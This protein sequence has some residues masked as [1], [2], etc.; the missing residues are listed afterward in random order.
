MSLQSTV[1][2]ILVVDHHCHGVLR[3][4]VNRAEFESMLTEADEPGPLNPTLFDSQIGFAVRRW[5]APVLGLEP[6]AQ[7]DAYLQR[8]T[9]IGHAEVTRRFLREAGTGTYIV[10]TGFVP[11]PILDPTEM[12]ATV[13]GVSLEVVRLE[14]VAEQ[15]IGEGVDASGFA[16]AV[17][18]RLAQRTANAVGVK[19][20][21]AYRAGLE[22]PGEQPTDAEVSAAAGRWLAALDAGAPPRC[23][24]RVL[25]SFLVWAGIELGKP[26]QFHVGLGDSDTDLRDGNPLLLTPL[27][28]ATQ[29]RGVPIMLLHNY[30][31]HRYAGYLAQVF[32]HVFL[33]LG[34]ATHNLGASSGRVIEE[35]LEL[36]PFGKVLFS[37]DA[38]G[39]PELYHLGTLLFRR[40]LAGVLRNGVVDGSWTELDAERT[41]G[42]ILAGNAI[43]AYRL[44]S[45]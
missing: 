27:L 6:H 44:G 41:A 36:A 18:E 15:V 28:R 2:E 20:I 17:R 25:H 5:C 42:M 26:V 29:S 21:A 39:L 24:D 16:A 10:D 19:S 33:D 30:P 32:S 31:F 8:R 13:D 11:E 9:E 40:G 43:R 4:D 38:F 22:L 34:L 12:A 3:R 45:A 7:P 23:Q 14:Q 1:D 37:S 35:L